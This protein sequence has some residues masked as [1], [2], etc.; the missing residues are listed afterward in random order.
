MS[1]CGCSSVDLH[2][3]IFRS[4]RSRCTFSSYYWWQLSS[5]VLSS[6]I[7]RST[8][9]PLCCQVIWASDISQSAHRNGPPNR[10]PYRAA[11]RACKCKNICKY[12]GIVRGIVFLKIEYIRR[13]FTPV[14]YFLL[15][16]YSRCWFCTPEWHFCR[17][18]LS[19]RLWNLF[20]CYRRHE[21][22]VVP[23]TWCSLWPDCRVWHFSPRSRVREAR[24]IDFQVLKIIFRC[25]KIF[26]GKAQ[27]RFGSA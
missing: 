24:A 7:L 15:T 9:D 16:F 4:N 13:E 21:Q 17:S 12:G 14:M 5:Y 3:T 11:A 23:V 19:K 6:G 2:W 1:V 10:N 25:G 8:S 20:L 18:L 22:F 27:V 26:A